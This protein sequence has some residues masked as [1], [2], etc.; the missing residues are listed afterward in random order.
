MNNKIKIAIDGPSGAGKST[1]AKNIANRLGFMYLDTGALYR[2]IGLYAYNNKINAK[3][4]TPELNKI[5]VDVEFRGDKQ[6]MYL[7]DVEVTEDIRQNEISGYASDVSAIPEVRRYLLDIQRETADKYDIIMDGRDI[8]TVILPDA[9]VKIFLNADV[10]ERADRRYNEL[11]SKGQQ[12]DYETVLKDIIKRDKNDSSREIAPLKPAD[13][14]VLFNN[15]GLE[16]HETLDCVLN[17][18]N[19]KIGSDFK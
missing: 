6:I 2:T 13:D 14:A 12:I 17:I 1:L 19:D 5:K 9:Q 18:I 10:N 8:G 7:N 16:E 3:D 4:I 15:T 11:L